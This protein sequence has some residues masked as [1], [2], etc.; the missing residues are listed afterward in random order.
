MVEGE[1]E[2]VL[3]QMKRRV[4]QYS[5]RV[6]NKMPLPSSSE[7]TGGVNTGSSVMFK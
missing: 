1:G 7:G 2:R 4:M 6:W 3:G 5:L